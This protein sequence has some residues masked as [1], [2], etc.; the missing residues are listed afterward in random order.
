M[1]T[2]QHASLDAYYLPD[3]FRI[4][5]QYQIINQ[6]IDSTLKVRELRITPQVLSSLCE[7]LCH[8]STAILKNIPIA[9][10]V[11]S[12]NT[13]TELW[14]QKH[15][16]DTA[17]L[18]EAMA[19]LSGFSVE[20]TAELLRLSKTTTTAA[21]LWELLHEEFTNPEVLD[22]L[23]LQGNSKTAVMAIAPEL[24]LTLLPENEELYSNLSIL[25]ALLVKSSCLCLAPGKPPVCAASYIRTLA[26]VNPDIGRCFCILSLHHDCSFMPGIVSRY[27][28]AVLNNDTSTMSKEN[29]KPSADSSKRNI[30]FM[31]LGNHISKSIQQ[32]KQICSAVAY[33]IAMFDQKSMF[34]PQ[35]IF[36]HEHTEAITR[37]LCGEIAQN[38]RLMEQNLPRGTL[39]AEKTAAIN[40]CWDE[41]ELSMLLGEDV[42][43]FSNRGKDNFLIY[44]DRRPKLEPTCA[45]RC[46]KI[47]PVQ[48]LDT[49]IKLLEPFRDNLLCAAVEMNNTDYINSVL[50]GCGITR[51]CSPGSM[52]VPTIHGLTGG[53]R[54]LSPLMRFC[55]AEHYSS[56]KCH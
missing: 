18:T 41:T 17:L 45:G 43:I 56:T 20:M 48:T 14:L 51:I 22:R 33:D 31:L 6:D 8:N 9:K 36:I 26:S 49:M 46:I 52:A 24:I 39:D 53:S 47:V 2:T 15:L 12:V 11:D 10:I 37:F 13:A 3:D 5:G 38:M 29:V 40:R 16:T 32:A 35:W 25:R 42:E 19:K 44:L 50:I 7:H 1:N 34:S 30:S 4:T 54:Y 27:A 28:G 55:H 23:T 21:A